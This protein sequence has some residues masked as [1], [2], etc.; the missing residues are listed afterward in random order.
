MSINK[1]VVYSCVVNIFFLQNASNGKSL[2]FTI[3]CIMLQS[4]D[5]LCVL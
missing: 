1:G 4:C 3:T 5:A 2:Q